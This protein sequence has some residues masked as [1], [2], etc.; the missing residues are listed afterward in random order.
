MITGAGS[1]DVRQ[2]VLPD[3]FGNVTDTLHFER[4]LA[5]RGF[6]SIAGTDEVGRGPLAGPVVAAAVILPSRCDTRL[7]RD[8]KRTTVTER[9]RLRDLLRQY[10]APIGIGCVDPATIDR[11]NIL[12][13]SLKAMASSIDD[14]VHQGF[15]PDFILVDGNK[16]LSISTPQEVVIKGDNRSASIAAASIVAKIF[17]DELMAELHDHYPVY[18]FLAN[19]GYPTS[20]HRQAVRRY[21]PSPVHRLSFKGVREFVSTRE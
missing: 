17:R 12:Q 16:P 15:A 9:Y 6:V 2:R 13:A 19:K 20:D 7:F 1:N 3:T 5:N 10:D 14:L 11:I 21:G 4:L 8:S 18:G